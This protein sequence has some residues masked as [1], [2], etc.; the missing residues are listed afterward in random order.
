MRYLYTNGTSD[1]FL[2]D[3]Q[4]VPEGF[5]PGRRSRE[6]KSHIYSQ[7]R[8]AKI[9]EA[10]KGRVPHNK[11]KKE[12]IKHVYYTDG[13][14]S[15]RVPFD[16]A[17]PPGFT[18]GRLKKRLDEQSRIK[19]AEKVHATKLARYGSSTYNN[20]QKNNLTKLLHY[21]NPTFNNSTQTRI[22]NIERYGV[23]IQFMRADL[24]Y[25]RKNSHPNAEF[26]KYLRKQGFTDFE[27]EF[28]IAPERYSYDFK[29]RN[30]LVE[31]DPFPF[32]NST[33]CPVKE[34]SPKAKD[35]H[36]NKSR[37]AREHSYRCV[38]IWDWDDLDKVVSTLRERPYTYARRCLIRE[39]SIEE[40]KAF[41]N[42]HHL[43]GYVSSEVRIGLYLNDNLIS[44]MTFGKP[45]YNKKY[46]WELLRYCSTYCVA[47]GAQKLFK[48]FLD[49]Y[50]PASIVSY[51]DLAKFCGDIYNTLGFELTQTS[52]GRHWYNA[53]LK[54]HITD[55][56]LRQR[57]FDQLLGKE[58]GTF[59]KGTSNDQLMLDHGF[60]EIY[61][62]GQATYVWKATDASVVN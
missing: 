11:G 47:G 34:G 12:T 20:T 35:Y 18:R 19:F 37:V 54:K 41:L 3:G 56:L 6:E 48:Y 14:V 43:Q 62:A 8:C 52:I 51:C 33:F 7:E 26:E 29:V 49:Q 2:E 4:P 60:V 28:I 13:K 32:H 53:R 31:I 61:D 23:P 5:F 57:G 40:E 36:F 1:I 46:K 25:P 42:V 9:S 22:T 58:F 21:G 16:V 24:N 39:P 30:T 55:N 38:H 17:P 59:G 50:H 45:R 44:I 10:C 15:I 27:R